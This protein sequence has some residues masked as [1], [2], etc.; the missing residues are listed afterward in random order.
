M[1]GQLSVAFSLNGS[2]GEVVTD[3]DG[4]RAPQVYVVITPYKHFFDNKTLYT[5]G[6]T[7]HI[8]GIIAN[9]FLYMVFCWCLLDFWCMGES[10]YENGC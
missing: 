8:W 3:G 9:V 5:I 2:C 4:A 6:Y 1:I 10:V 7:P